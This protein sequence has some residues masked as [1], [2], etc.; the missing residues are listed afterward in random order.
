MKMTIVKYI[1]I[2]NIHDQLAYYYM[3]MTIVKCISI[4]NLPDQLAHYFAQCELRQFASIQIYFGSSSNHVNML[5]QE[6]PN[7]YT[8]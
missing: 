3:K 1:S 8:L 5:Q 2:E 4:G 6:I 7:Y